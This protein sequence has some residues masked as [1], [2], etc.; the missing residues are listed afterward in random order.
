MS[1]ATFRRLVRAEWT[2]FST[3]PGWRTG[4]A[5]AALMIVLFAVLTAASATGGTTPVPVGP[6]GGPVSDS[7]Y[8]VHQPL[9]GDGAITVAVTSLTTVIGGDPDGREPTVPW[10]KAG[11]IIK[12]GATPGTS[13]AAV[14]VTGGH[15]VR[16]QHD[17][18]HDTAGEPGQASPS[19][20]RWLRL[21]RAGDT[22]TGE[23]SV[24]GGRWSRVS[25]V[26]LAGLPTVVQAGLFVACPNDVD[27]RGTRT[28][29]ATA[30]F[31]RPDLQ[32]QWAQGRWDGA[33][34]GAEV[35]TFG[36]YPPVPG[37]VDVHGPHMT[38]GS[39]P[40]GD[41]FTVTGAGDIAPAARFEVP[42]GGTV[43]D[44]L[45][46]TFTALIAMSVVGT[47]FITAEY[48]HALI[49]TT[50]SAGP[51]RLRVLAA[52]AVVLG[53][54]T[55]L[56]TLPA[57]ALAVPLSERIARAQGLYLFPVST[58]T[59]VRV[60]LGTAA[61]LALTAVFALGVG[62]LLR[63]SATAVTTVVVTVVLPHVLVLTPILPA[64]AQRWLTLVTPDAAFA[65]QH[66]IVR[67]AHVDSI[68]TPSSG[69]YPLGPWSGLAVLA[70]YAA[71]ALL[72]AAFAL[73]RRDA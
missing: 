2:K 73:R 58:A 56:T 45:F 44:L 17:F 71:A 60:A 39:V 72:L 64:S 67:Y 8:F 27:G 46:G 4:T 61:L 70:G 14:M 10:A 18:V 34:V 50:L 69:Y 13:Y 6:H 35:A 26:R 12:D 55:F 48:R 15:G 5:A 54:V 28:A 59:A 31:G 62:T 32:G 7:F 16:M 47:L 49:R 52:K 41:G 11:L 37:E 21:T 51:Q 63:R 19:A 33:Q 9:R 42:L 25:T 20:P 23:T 3:V 30:V 22:I 29:A 38:G 66:T 43:S 1:D 36:G 40:T 68:Y 57:T 65:V 53:G 24:D